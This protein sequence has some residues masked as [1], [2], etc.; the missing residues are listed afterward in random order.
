MLVIQKDMH[1]AYGV[2]NGTIELED[3]PLYFDK[4][5]GLVEVSKSRF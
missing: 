1:K 2:W 3:G 5:F 4:L